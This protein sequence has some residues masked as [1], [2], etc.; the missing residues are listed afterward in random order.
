MFAMTRRAS[1]LLA[2][3]L[4]IA[5]ASGQALPWKI[6]MRQVREPIPNGDCGPIE[7]NV[8]DA[9]GKTPLT[10][11][12]KQI[13]WQDFDITL[14]Q[15]AGP[16]RL[17]GNGRFLCATAPGATGV[18]TAT[19]PESTY[20]TGGGKGRTGKKL[21]AGANATASLNVRSAGAASP[22]TSPAPPT[23]PNMAIVLAEPVVTGTTTP[24]QRPAGSSPVP[25]PSTNLPIA[26]GT[27]LATVSTLETTPSPPPVPIEAPP[28][29]ATGLI[30]TV[31]AATPE[32]PAPLSPGEAAAL[33]AVPIG[34]ITTI[35]DVKMDLGSPYDR[36]ALSHF[37]RLM[38]GPVKCLSTRFRIVQVEQRWG[39]CRRK[40]FTTWRIPAIT[41]TPNSLGAGSKQMD[42]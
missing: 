24:L 12:G 21:I 36:L 17:T 4:P 6:D 1:L 31:V 10:P 13:D 7:L 32:S 3:Q 9:T 41:G 5:V 2:L 38:W 15:G 22:A 27:P 16:L 8:R 42:G 25:Q 19:Y 30:P 14:T 20:L 29:G 39:E 33:C 35:E 37:F 23:A 26:T 40:S 18:V 28:S 34:S 11:D